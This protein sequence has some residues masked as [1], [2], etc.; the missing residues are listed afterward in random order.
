MV[1]VWRAAM[2]VVATVG[3]LGS[4]AQ[5]VQAQVPWP[6]GVADLPSTWT[7]AL[8]GT[9]GPDTAVVIL[10]YGLTP[11]G[12]MRE[13]LVRR[14]RA[15]LLQAALAPLSPVI[16]TGGN[17]R[18]GI[19]EAD[20]MA[21]WLVANGVAPERILREDRADSTVQNARRTA[22]MM[23]DRG[24]RAAVLVT[25]D[26]H[27]VRAATAFADADVAVVGELTPDRIP[28]FVQPLWLG[29]FGAGAV[30]AAR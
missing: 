6:T 18:A 13:E 21:A 25:S 16:V 12:A 4:A 1:S 27:I 28:W 8:P 9:Y 24:L 29:S 22:T 5:I 23:A 10:G 3:L 26:D 2:A 15:G 20:A 7:P 19:T 14:L 17:P 11:E 30:S